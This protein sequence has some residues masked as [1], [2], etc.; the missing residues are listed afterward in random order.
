M[1]I[2]GT[3]VTVKLPNGYP[4]GPGVHAQFVLAGPTLKV[5]VSN[6]RVLLPNGKQADKRPLAVG[7]QVVMVLSAPDAGSAATPGSLPNVSRTSFATIIERIVP[8]D[9]VITH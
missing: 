6:A 7:D 8:N 5:D 2:D 4:G 3:L 9:K 1:A